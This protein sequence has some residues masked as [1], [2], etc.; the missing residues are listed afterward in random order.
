MELAPDVVDPR[1]VDATTNIEV[2]D[3]AQIFVAKIVYIVSMRP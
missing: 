2:A 1:H 3:R